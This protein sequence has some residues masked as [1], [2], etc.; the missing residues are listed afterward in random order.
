MPAFAQSLAA[1]NCTGCP[2]IVVPAAQAKVV[3]VG[4]AVFLDKVCQL[5]GPRHTMKILDSRVE[6]SDSSHA[7]NI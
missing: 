1:L 2:K 3:F 6:G 5:Q 7:H 4:S